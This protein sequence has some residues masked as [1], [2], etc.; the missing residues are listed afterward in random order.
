[1]SKLNPSCIDEVIMG[2]VVV[3]SAAPNLAREIILDLGLPPQIP[4]VTCS[5]ACL[6]GLQVILIFMCS[7]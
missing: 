2:N 6:S 3:K 7:Y 5:R 4:G 1:M